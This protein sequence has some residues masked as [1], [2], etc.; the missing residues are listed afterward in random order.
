M[1]VTQKRF[2][3]LFRKECR[4]DSDHPHQLDLLPG[5]H[6]IGVL[7][8]HE[9]GVKT[10]ELCRRHGISNATFYNGNAKYGGLTVILL[11]LDDIVYAREPAPLAGQYT[12]LKLF[13]ACWVHDI[14]EAVRRFSN[15]TT[16]TAGFYN[17]VGFNDD[18][19]A[20]LSIPTRHDVARRID[21]G[22]LAQLILADF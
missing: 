10:P 7:R 18:I 16:E 15:T 12:A 9:A 1:N 19:R 13:P 14:P 2:R 4:F 20:F 5:I 17:S 3:I 21:C 11:T 6:T 22:F 8:K